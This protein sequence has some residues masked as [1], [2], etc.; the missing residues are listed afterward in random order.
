MERIKGKAVGSLILGA[1][2]LLLPVLV[3]AELEPVGTHVFCSKTV[4]I[5]AKL[6]SAQPLRVHG[7]CTEILSIADTRVNI[8]IIGDGCGKTIVR[9]SD[10]SASEII[11]I[12]GRNIVV[13][14]L[15][16]HGLKASDPLVKPALGPPDWLGSCTGTDASDGACNNNRG[17]RLQR[18]GIAQIGRNVT[19]P[20]DPTAF[21]EQTG[22]IGRASCRE[23]VYVLV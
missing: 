9:G 17:I 1:I 3:G 19:D 18:G 22:E 23:R 11:Q 12:R 8:T 7:T 13:T 20:S 6:G 14:N 15:E 2:L 10:P 16:I 21:I 5:G 4:T